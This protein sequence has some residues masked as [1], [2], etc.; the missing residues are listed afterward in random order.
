M[1]CVV[2]ALPWEFLGT[3]ESLASVSWKTNHD[4]KLWDRVCCKESE[5][6][7]C[8]DAHAW[9]GGSKMRVNWLVLETDQDPG[10]R[11]S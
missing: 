7:V 9:V 3:W 10:E 2:P 8:Y 1:F 6:I 11:I 4:Q 5:V